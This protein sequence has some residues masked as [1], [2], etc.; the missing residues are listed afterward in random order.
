M[1]GNE[2]WW[3]NDA[4]DDNDAD[5]ADDAD[6]TSGMSQANTPIFDNKCLEGPWHPSL[7]GKE[8]AKWVTLTLTQVPKP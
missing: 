7:V 5:D 1:G 3:L 2:D 6:D 8:T 4:D